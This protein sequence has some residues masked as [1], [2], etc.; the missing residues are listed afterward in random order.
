[1]IVMMAM[2]AL[3]I[4]TGYM[5]T[6]QTQLDRSVDAAALAGAA[7]L[8]DGTDVAQQAAIEYLIRNPVGKQAT[9]VTSE[10]MVELTAKFLAEHANDYDILWGEWNP[11][12][13][14]I[15]PDGSTAL[16]DFRHDELPEHAVLLRC[17]LGKDSFDLQSTAIAMYQ[18][19][20]IMLVLDFSGSMSDDSQFV[21]DR[22]VWQAGD[23]GWPEP[24]VRGTWFAR[25]TATCCS[26]NRSTSRSRA[27]RTPTKP[28]WNTGTNPPT[29][30]RPRTSRV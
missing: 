2:L 20:D 16:G 4:D 18:P 30:L 15:D 11:A 27:R 25:S 7:A 19:R 6:M 12:T 9:A 17:A 26:S 23:H 29:S 5:Y 14:Q 28:P 24:D 13:G 1:M 3:S 10:E 8:I 22:H 21:V